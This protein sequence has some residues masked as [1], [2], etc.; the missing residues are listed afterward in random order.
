MANKRTPLEQAYLDSLRG[1]A[2]R[3]DPMP[4]AFMEEIY[5]MPGMR[6]TARVDGLGESD[7]GSA[8]G[9]T[10]NPSNMLADYNSTRHSDFDEG[11]YEDHLYESESYLRHLSF[12]YEDEE[13]QRTSPIDFETGYEDFIPAGMEEED[14]SNSNVIFLDSFDK[15]P[16]FQSSSRFRVPLSARR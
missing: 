1:W 15:K 6:I 4:E 14:E 5:S 12:D 9:H 2:K 8:A 7:Y 13:P 16:S 10:F 11:D 3:L